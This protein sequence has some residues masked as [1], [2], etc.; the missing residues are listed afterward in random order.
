MGVAPNADLYLYDFSVNY[1][2]TNWATMA[3]DAESL[4][5]VVMNNSW[6]FDDQYGS[7]LNNIDDLVTYKTNN[8]LTGA[9]TLVHYQGVDADGDG[10]NDVGY[11]SSQKS[12]TVL[13][14][15]I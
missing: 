11:S 2:P 15:F 8:S 9:E 7:T 3:G 1:S 5:S 13:V 12:W 14:E 10:Y 6:G 4:G